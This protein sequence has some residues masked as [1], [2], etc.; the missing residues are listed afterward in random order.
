[1]TTEDTRD[2]IRSALNT[3]GLTLNSEL[4]E[5]FASELAHHHGDIDADTFYEQLESYL[6]AH[7]HPTYLFSVPVEEKTVATRTGLHRVRAT[8]AVTAQVLAI[9]QPD[10]D[11]T[12]WTDWRTTPPEFYAGL[13]SGPIPVLIADRDGEAYTIT[14]ELG[15]GLCLGVSSDDLTLHLYHDGHPLNP[16]AFHAALTGTP[17]EPFAAALRTYLATQNAES[18]RVLLTHD[19]TGLTQRLGTLTV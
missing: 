19:L 7:G 6:I 13:P 1:M 5:Q 3:M 2:R 10:D 18:M 4:T 15:H 8:H 9:T 16:D 17:D 12:D 14:Q 11:Q